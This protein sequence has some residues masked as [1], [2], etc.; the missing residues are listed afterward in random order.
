LK[1]K[2]AF[3]DTISEQGDSKRIPQRK[4]KKIFGLSGKEAM[5]ESKKVLFPISTA[6]SVMKFLIY[7]KK[8]G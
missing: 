2:N 4:R 6:L 3:D 8:R 1:N 5:P 7:L